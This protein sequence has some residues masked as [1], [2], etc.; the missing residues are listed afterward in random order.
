MIKPDAI[1]L[2]NYTENESASAII[3]IPEETADHLLQ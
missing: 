3:C 1:V 2:G